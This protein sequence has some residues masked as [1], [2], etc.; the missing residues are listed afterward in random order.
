MPPT[1]KEPSSSKRS[2]NSKLI[3]ENDLLKPK[4]ES[5]QNIILHLACSRQD[6]DEQ[7]SNTITNISYNPV[8]E[9]VEP[10]YDDS[11]FHAADYKKEQDFVQQ[12]VDNTHVETSSS[13]SSPDE[14][15][16]AL[17]EIWA[18]LKQLEKS[19]HR[20]QVIDK[21]P[22]CFWCTCDFNN[23]PVYLPKYFLNKSYHVYGCF[24]TPECAV[25]Y[26]M[27]E[28]LDSSTKFERYHILNHL[29]GKIFGYNKNIKPA[30]SPYYLLDKY[31]GNLSIQE[32]RKLL[33]TNDMYMVVDKPLTHIMPEIHHDSADFSINQKS[34]SSLSGS[35][36]MKKRTSTVVKTKNE[37]LQQNFM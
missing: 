36:Q 33:G 16:V 35:L 5:I 11:V 25:S 26:L 34:I 17:K 14:S 29:Y 1:K 15:V 27:N 32:Y 3:S 4:E 19:L 28:T 7:Y 23:P 18:K 30:P 9:Q 22:A 6:L 10:F 21:K 37:I 2:K 31:Y 13:S 20:N 12:P 8:I 24:C